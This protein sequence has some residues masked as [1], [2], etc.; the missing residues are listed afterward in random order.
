MAVPLG[1]VGVGMFWLKLVRTRDGSTFTPLAVVELRLVGGEMKRVRPANGALAAVDADY[2][3]FAAGPAL[4]PQMAASVAR[5]VAEVQSAM[6]PWAAR[7]MYLNLAETSRRPG[8]FWT[9]EAYHRLRR[10]KAAVD[11]GNL[12]RSNHPIPPHHEGTSS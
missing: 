5:S 10:I 8:S 7:Q 6:S 12:I 1:A 2:A 11:P 4:F 3:F 9:P